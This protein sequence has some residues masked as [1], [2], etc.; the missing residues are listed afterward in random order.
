MS[1]IYRGWRQIGYAPPAELTLNNALYNSVNKEEAWKEQ[2]SASAEEIEPPDSLSD[3]SSVST[4][5]SEEYNSLNELHSLEGWAQQPRQGSR[6][7][8]SKE[9]S[10]TSAKVGDSSLKMNHSKQCSNRVKLECFNQDCTSRVLAP[11]LV[12]PLVKLQ[13][14]GWLDIEDTIKIEAPVP[15]KS[16]LAM[17]LS[18]LLNAPFHTKVDSD[19]RISTT[20]SLETTKV[21]KH[22]KSLTEIDARFRNCLKTLFMNKVLSKSVKFKSWATF[23][24]VQQPPTHTQSRCCPT[25][26]PPQEKVDEQ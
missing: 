4:P 8:K 25:A 9:P 16:L 1:R 2:F 11:F 23:G 13:Q 12:S 15:G 22:S 3:S 26:P 7:P 5:N 21:I 19:F 18:E 24:V 6:L 14:L 17:D 20:E 10:L